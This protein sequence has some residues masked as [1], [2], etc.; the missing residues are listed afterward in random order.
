MGWN[1]YFLLHVVL[2]WN[3]HFLLYVVMGWKHNILSTP[4][5]VVGNFTFKFLERL[6]V[7]AFLF[8]L[9]EDRAFLYLTLKYVDFKNDERH[10]A[11]E[12]R[13][14]KDMFPKLPRM[15]IAKLPVRWYLLGYTVGGDLN[16]WHGF[17]GR[18]KS[19]YIIYYQVKTVIL[20]V[21]YY[22]SIFEVIIWA[23]LIEK[24]PC[25]IIYFRLR[26]DVQNVQL[27]LCAP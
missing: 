14:P 2:G 23:L 5:Q 27:V 10:G 21:D 24:W 16:P 3:W 11:E 12:W 22:F 9:R 4:F 7:F 20:V 13:K 26:N 17:C 25:L 8:P 15:V 18:K 6:A 19:M 1:W